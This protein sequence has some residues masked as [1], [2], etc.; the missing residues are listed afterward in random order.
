L[1]NEYLKIFDLESLCR[2]YTFINNAKKAGIY[3]KGLVTILAPLDRKQYIDFL[4]EI[5]KAVPRDWFGL[6][7]PRKSDYRLLKS[8]LYRIAGIQG[9]VDEAIN[10]IN[11]AKPELV[12]V[13]DK[14]TVIEELSVYKKILDI[15][16][17]KFHDIK[18]TYLVEFGNSF[19]FQMGTT[20]FPGEVLTSNT[21]YEF[22]V[23]ESRERKTNEGYIIELRPL[24]PVTEDEVASIKT[25]TRSSNDAIL[26]NYIEKLIRD[27]QYDTL[28]PL[29]A[30]VLGIKKEAPLSRKDIDSLPDHSYHNKN[31]L[32]NPAQKQAVALACA[33]DGIHN[34]LE[35]VQG[36]PGTG[37][38]TLIKEIALQYY[39][40]GKN[41][42]I[43][44]KTNVAVDNILE[45]LIEDKLRVLRTGNNIE[46]KSNLPYA[47]AV[48]TS[49]PVY[50]SMLEGTN[51]IVLGTPLGFYLD[52]NMET[53][54]YD[55]VIIDEASQMD[56][57]ETLFS[58]G[59]ANKCVII[60]DHM[61]IPP[62]PVQNEVLLEY[63]PRMDLY[64]SEELQK[65]LFEK[66]IT[67]K[68][69]FNSV[70][71][72][73]NYRTE[74]PKMV[75]FISD[76]IYDGKL[77]PNT[78][79]LY[80]KVPKQKRDGIF[81]ENPIEI[82]DTSEFLDPEARAETEEN[83]TYYNISEAMMSVKKVIE[84]LNMGEKLEDICIITPYK[85]QTEKLKE[86]F[87]THS[88][89]FSNSDQSLDDFI[90]QNIY[91]IDSF[92]GR[93]QENVIINWVRSNY[94]N[95]GTYTRTGFLRD[96]RRINVALSRAKKRL[97]LIGDF[98]TL[99]KSDNMKVQY[100]FSKIKSINRE[101]KIVL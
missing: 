58:L 10:K 23:V 78:D 85:A 66:L 99:T 42:L 98:A 9:A 54:D 16:I 14:K 71:L 95:P 35:I 92:Q 12:Q 87:R 53:Q 51:K 30:V 55:I 52:R 97:I 25:F 80:Y 65:S 34:V 47:P 81:L 13:K 63:D 50:M 88:K 93:E 40:A 77:Y 37:K 74:N 2:K 29:M 20:F 57:P 26:S 61:Q 6:R 28:S 7:K 45:K 84:L 17:R 86:V 5:L 94:S 73:I 89:Y 69:R 1:I 56:V 32:S 4:Y 67:D 44:A 21:G 46:F 38:T 43:L 27:I 59:F 75:S 8:D 72:D 36:P 48:S 101:E 68:N 49:N 70:F 76:L 96:Y 15:K 41:V 19:I 79:S 3:R 33:L 82:I 60:G 83:S 11:F 39:D 90:E 64:T 22:E 31:L 24:E 100:I 62:F 91:T 18:C